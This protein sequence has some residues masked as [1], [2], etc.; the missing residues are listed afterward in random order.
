MIGA[1][2][3][4]AMSPSA[5]S[6]ALSR[7]RNSFSDELF[8]RYGSAMQPTAQAEQMAE[9]VGSALQLLSGRLEGVG[10]FVAASSTQTFT[11]AASDSP[12]LPCCP[13]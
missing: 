7:L 10:P 1:A 2:E 12:L 8:V 4:L 13:A 5:C 9:A 3:E 6:H 11:F